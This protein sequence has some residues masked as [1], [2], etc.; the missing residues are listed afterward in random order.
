MSPQKKY[1]HI[2]WNESYSSGLVYLDNHRR[3]F[4]DIVNE[5]VDVVN[6]ETCSATL[7]MIFHRLAF[8]VEEYFV[9]KEIALMGNSDLPLHSYKKEHA[10]FTA[11]VTRQQEAFFVGRE[12]VCRDLLDFIIE[13]YH[14]YIGLFGPEAVE[15]LRGKGFE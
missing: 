7:P 14:N 10:I 9:N 8:Y 4:I 3:N 6:E 15:Y 11:E 1:D 5:L 2:I 12:K 13:W